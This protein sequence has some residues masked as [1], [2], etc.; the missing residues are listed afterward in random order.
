MFSDCVIVIQCKEMLAGMG[1]EATALML[2]VCLAF[3]CQK[4]LM[5]KLVCH[6]RT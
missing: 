3:C 4:K 2:C 6:F 5:N 1:A